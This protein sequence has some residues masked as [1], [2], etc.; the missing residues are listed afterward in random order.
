MDLREIENDILK[1]SFTWYEIG[2]DKTI[3]FFKSGHEDKFINHWISELEEYYR[4]QGADAVCVTASAFDSKKKFDV[5]ILPCSIEFVDDPVSFVKTALSYLSVNGRL[6]IMA[7]N[8]LGLRYFCGDKDYHTGRQFDGIDGYI[9]ISEQNKKYVSGRAFSKRELMNVIHDAGINRTCIYSVF[10]NLQ[11]PQL[12]YREDIIPSVDKIHAQYCPLY[13]NRNSVYLYENSLLDELIQNGVFHAI[14]NAYVIECS[15]DDNFSGLAY[16]EYCINGLRED[17][18]VKRC[19][20][21]LDKMQ[22]IAI[23]NDGIKKIRKIKENSLILRNR[24]I[25]VVETYY[26]ESATEMKYNGTEMGIN[27]LSRLVRLDKDKFLKELDR[28]KSMIFES[29]ESSN[30]LNPDVSKIVD[31]YGEKIENLGKI[32]THAFPDMCVSRVVYEKGVFKLSEQEHKIDNIPANVLVFGMIRDV[33]ANIKDLSKYVEWDELLDRY[34]L[35]EKK[36]LWSDIDWMYVCRYRHDDIVKLWRER[37]ELSENAVNSNRK[38]MELSIQEYVRVFVDLFKNIGNRKLIIFGSG[39]YAAKF[40][41]RYGKRYPVYRVLD[42]NE[43]RQGE[44]LENVMIVSPDILKEMKPDEYK[45]IICV[46]QFEN[47]LNQIRSM[48]VVN[49]SVFDPESD[50]QS[51]PEPKMDRSIVNGEKKKYHIGYVAGVFDLF[52]KGHLNLLRRAK[53]QCDY[54][55]AGVCTDEWVSENKN[56]STFIPFE[57]RLEIVG[58]C[59][60]V[61]RAVEIPLYDSGIR[62]AWR[63]YH[64]DVQFSGNDHDDSAG[65]IADKR[66]LEERGADIVFFPYTQSTSS[67]KLKELINSRLKNRS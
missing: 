22:T 12:I 59:K 45:I 34:G 19:N 48:G 66:F 47:V 53:E 7:N 46:K 51:E 63:L 52:H 37:Y 67:T 6:L 39:Q 11:L 15:V 49:Y 27:Y 13:Y 21:R 55:I 42:N 1:G 30:L 20:D 38:K 24:N 29:S 33:Y 60:Y 2:K 26:S 36:M 56:T 16:A 62:E 5:V 3:L 25:P 57:E 9:K 23:F 4:N 32:L 18:I 40:L 65:W 17:A 31:K 14:A 61:D 44:V 35:L 8:R 10:P 43:K 50:L 28:L 41:Q 58:A 54:L 64:F